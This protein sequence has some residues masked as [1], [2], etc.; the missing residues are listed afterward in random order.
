MASNKHVWF[1][2]VLGVRREA[3]IARCQ[4]AI[5]DGRADSFVYLVA[6][7]P[8]LDDVVNRI[9]DGR[10]IAASREL[11]VFLFDGLIRR[12]LKHSGET[13]TIIE[14]P[15]KL[16]LMELTMAELI[17][18]GSLRHL[19]E[20]ASLPG[21]ISSVARIIGEIKRSDM[22]A[23]AFQ[24]F[25]A[26]T[27]PHARDVDVASI[28]QA[29]S[30]T[31]DRLQLLDADDAYVRALDILRLRPDL[32]PWLNLTQRLFIDGFFDFTPV[33]KK[34]L[35]YLIERI[36]EVI[37][38]LTFDPNNSPVFEEPL[39]D[40]RAFL[41]TLSEP[42]LN[43]QFFDTRPYDPA[44]GRLRVGL[45]N[46]SF[47]EATLEEVMPDTDDQAL[48]VNVLAAAGFSHECETI[49]KEIKRI[50]LGEKCRAGEMAVIARDPAYL[51][52][53]S[54]ELSRS[55]IPVAFD[56]TVS[57][58]TLAPVKAA[59]KVLDC[60]VSEAAEPY[61]AVLKNDYL[62]HFSQLD[63]DAIENALLA[64]GTQISVHQLRR[65]I[66]DTK[67]VK[68][69][70]AKT[71][72]SRTVD[73]EEIQS[74]LARIRRGQDALEAALESIDGMRD[75]L[76]LIPATGTIPD[77]VQGFFKALRKFRLKERIDE[78][79]G[80]VGKNEADLGLIARDL[81]GLRALELVLDDLVHLA[82][83]QASGEASHEH[84]SPHPGAWLSHREFTVEE[85]REL[86]IRLIQRTEFKLE[87]GDP[88]GVRLLEATGARGLAFKVVFIPGLTEGG[89][90]RSPERDWVYPDAER[91]KLAEAGLFL[92]DLSPRVFQ[93]KEAHFFFHSACQAT[94]RLYLTYPR[95]D[96]TGDETVV[97]G[98]IEEVQQV[99]GRRL[100][101][102]Q[103]DPATYDVQ[104]A[105]SHAELQR[106][107]VASLYQTTPGDSLV[108]KLY[109]QAVGSG[110]LPP[111]LFV[112]L[113]IERVRETAEF[114]PFSGLVQNQ[115]IRQQLALRYGAKHV[116][117]PSQLN[118]YGRCP[119]QF[120][121][122]RVLRLEKREEASLDLIA[123]DRGF[124]LHA[125][126]HDFMQRHTRAQLVP[127]RRREYQ[128]E[129]RKTA[130]T[131]FSHYEEKA[132][133]VNRSL[134]ELQK[135][136]MTDA[137]I[138][139]LDGE[140]NY[141]RRVAS[142]Q[143]RPHWLEIGFGMSDKEGCHPDSVSV[144]LV[145]RRPIPA[146]P[147][148]RATTDTIQ[149]RGRIDRVDRSSDG[150]YI[151]YDYKSSRGS[152]VKEMR[153]GADLQ[154]HL[155]IRA[156][157]DLFQKP[158]EEV[159]GGGYYSIKDRNRNNGLYREDFSGH[160]AIG[161]TAR[162]NMTT[163]EWA[164]ILEEGETF[165]WRYVDGMRRGDFRILP[166]EDACCPRCD[167]KTVCRFDKQKNRSSSPAT[168]NEQSSTG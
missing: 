163:E 29:Y 26:A 39:K 50:V 155:Y 58:A 52:T 124:L 146:Q 41:S 31:M 116:Y 79:L 150:K 19:R 126:L 85:F 86:V 91:R 38:N 71:L 37:V 23:D 81:R 108:L 93:A 114:G 105:T 141:Q 134:W 49:A 154:M 73:V 110:L 22:P 165:A 133:P 5:L 76:A 12:I 46:P 33:Q 160:T 44:L 115:I 94:E 99:Y 89:F 78:H 82:T 145:L 137:L 6:T 30:Q 28:Y 103:L 70:Q 69:Y 168:T 151:V 61:V 83:V 138:Q 80:S 72:T 4:H 100:G 117:S 156:V 57:L 135:A 74:E 149:V 125:I 111:S 21:C 131:V 143:M 24:E 132:L 75:A 47:E 27:A 8:L 88:A 42:T 147:G 40:T 148:T 144:N 87:R 107:V 66:R 130:E 164:T 153:E 32:P 128:E 67:E 166:K 34:L 13:R 2:P 96:S 36:P 56:Q 45:F 60:R 43:Q 11:R 162:S 109:N 161:S 59:M 121:C 64:V 113:G 118:T 51:E 14:E 139:F 97:S 17:E 167:F 68:E 159:I 98:F 127:E 55:R 102:R 140:I 157:K 152:T 92:E 123:V 101:I 112:R 53:V 136:E 95:S 35:R 84:D 106:T 62:D 122:Q 77:L 142:V 15:T 120:F 54:D 9:V 65:R 1:E 119:F 158:D 3:L 63:R 10:T 25:V 48:P 20:I 104:Q 16:L 18:T 129:M 90:P 7:R